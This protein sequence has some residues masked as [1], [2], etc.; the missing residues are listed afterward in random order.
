MRLNN[1]LL[2][3]FVQLALAFFFSNVYALMMTFTL[4]LSFSLIVLVNWLFSSF[5]YYSKCLNKVWLG[6]LWGGSAKNMLSNFGSCC[7]FM[8]FESMNNAEM[9]AQSCKCTMYA[10][11]QKAH[12]RCRWQLAN[13]AP[14]LFCI[15]VLAINSYDL[16]Q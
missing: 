5:V 4:L 3:S 2:H 1:I 8:F 12:S 10:L 9:V 7:S 16:S 15:P 13:G 6:Y 14:W 11:L